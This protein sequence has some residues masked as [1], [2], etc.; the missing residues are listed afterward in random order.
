MCFAAALL[1]LAAFTVSRCI[2]T[3]SV[4][5]LAPCCPCF[6]SSI[7]WVSARCCSSLR[8]FG[9]EVTWELQVSDAHVALRQIL[10]QHPVL[11]EILSLCCQALL[12]HVSWRAPHLEPCLSGR[13][14]GQVIANVT[15]L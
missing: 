8:L 1:S 9:L 2:Y 3:T 7:R 10:Q 12:S 14:L 6:P 13:A 5:R 11:N 15:H 4:H